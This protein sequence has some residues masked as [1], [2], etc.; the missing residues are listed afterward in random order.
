MDGAPEVPEL[1]FV[2]KSVATFS[3]PVRIKYPIPGLDQRNDHRHYDPVIDYRAW[4][5]EVTSRVATRGF[6]RVKKWL[7]QLR[8]LP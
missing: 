7:R 1:T 2:H 8:G 6:R 4:H 5:L 3:G